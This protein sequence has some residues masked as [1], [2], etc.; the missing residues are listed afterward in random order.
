MPTPSNNNN[1]QILKLAR[2]QAVVKVVSTNPIT[3]NLDVASLTMNDE[4]FLG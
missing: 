3:A 2:Q 1:I 4:T